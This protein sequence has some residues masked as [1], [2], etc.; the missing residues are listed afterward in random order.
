V[1]PLPRA[2]VAD[3]RAHGRPIAFL[4]RA[5][6]LYR[7]HGIAVGGAKTAPPYRSTIDANRGASFLVGQHLIAFIR[8]S[9][10]AE[11]P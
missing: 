10:E 3:G 5:L 7:R 2:Q 9:V 6:V 1:V 8:T 4:R 11:S